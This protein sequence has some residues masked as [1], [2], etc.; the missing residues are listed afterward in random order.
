MPLYFLCNSSMSDIDEIV[1]VSFVYFV[2]F[3]AALGMVSLAVL[4]P[5]FYIRV[6]MELL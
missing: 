4:I 2:C 3:A 5:Y 1:V 6:L